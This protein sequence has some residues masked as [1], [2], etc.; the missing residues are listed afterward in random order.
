MPSRL[1]APALGELP[2][3]LF[4]SQKPPFH[5]LPAI[6]IRRERKRAKLVR[7][8]PVWLVDAPAGA[9][10]QQEFLE[11]QIADVAAE[12]IQKTQEA[13]LAV[14]Q[15]WGGV[16]DFTEEISLVCTPRDSL[17]PYQIIASGWSFDYAN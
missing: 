6:G 14:K 1:S 17:A 8:E 3:I 10:Q 15:H 2:T 12:R 9:E 5:Q 11:I 13:F 16:A 4:F 7:H